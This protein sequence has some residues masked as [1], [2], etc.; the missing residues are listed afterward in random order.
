MTIYN[1]S[2]CIISIHYIFPKYINMFMCLN[3]S[4]LVYSKCSINGQYK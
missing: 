4:S 1:I 2:Q 3:K